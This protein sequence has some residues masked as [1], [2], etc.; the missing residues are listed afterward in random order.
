MEYLIQS[1]NGTIYFYLQE[2]NEIEVTERHSCNMLNS[3]NGGDY[4]YGV[5]F[6]KKGPNEWILSYWND[7]DFQCCPIC[8]NQGCNHHD[9]DYE[10]VDHQFVLDKVKMAF[11]KNRLVR[12]IPSEL[13]L[14]NIVLDR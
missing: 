7:S 12:G 14:R 6:K 5:S 2:W 11:E 8:G 1:T 3:H 10:L 4:T 13:K 9:D